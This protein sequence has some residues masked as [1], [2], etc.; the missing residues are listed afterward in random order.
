MVL[1]EENPLVRVAQLSEQTATKVTI[2][3]PL[4]N[5]IQIAEVITQEVID[6]AVEV[7]HQGVQIRGLLNQEIKD[8]ERTIRNYN[9]CTKQHYFISP[10]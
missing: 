3:I 4:Q 10:E 1:T 9:N 6:R 8:E 2:R 7:D 5:Q